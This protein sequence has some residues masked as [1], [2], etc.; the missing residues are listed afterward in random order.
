MCL[1]GAFLPVR[2]SRDKTYLYTLNPATI[3]H[4]SNKIDHHLKIVDYYIHCGMP[5]N[6]LVEPQLGKYEPDLYF[7]DGSKNI[8]VEIQLTPISCKKMQQKINNFV[9]EYGVSHDSQTIVICSDTDYKSLTIPKNFRLI[10]Q[11]IPQEKLIK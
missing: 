1:N 10:K 5:E 4:R 7:N 9:T 3:H 2:Q 11:K 6:C 8:C